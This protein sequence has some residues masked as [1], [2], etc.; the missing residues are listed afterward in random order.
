MFHGEKVMKNIIA[1]VIALVIAAWII[2]SAINSLERDVVKK[3]S[4]TFAAI[5][6]EIA[7][8]NSRLVTE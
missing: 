6:K 8:N 2:P 4:T 7:P 5:S 1:T 3:F